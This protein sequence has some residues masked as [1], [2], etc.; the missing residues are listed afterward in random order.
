MTVEL[1]FVDDLPAPVILDARRVSLDG[2]QHLRRLIIDNVLPAG[3]VLLQ[4]QL[5]RTFGVSR[6]PMREAF[7]MLQAEGLIDAETTPRARV[8]DLDPQELDQ[9]YSVRI[10]LE[11][12]GTRITAGRLTAD[13]I[14]EATASL[15]VML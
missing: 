13:E 1:S 8:R 5:A 3:T 14:V 11:S 7:R 4:A 12:L 10:A 15:E 6:T 9:L 2:H